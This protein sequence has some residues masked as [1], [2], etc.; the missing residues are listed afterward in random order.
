MVQPQDAGAGGLPPACG[1]PSDCPADFCTPYANKTLAALARD[2]MGPFLLAGIAVKVNPRVVP[3]WHQYLY[4]GTG[5]QD[6]SSEFGRDFTRSPTTEDTTDFLVEAIRESIERD[7]PVFPPGESEVEVDLQ[8]RIPATLSRVGTGSNPEAMNFNIPEDIP[9]NIAGGVGKTQTTCP[10]GAQPGPFDD[11]R[12]A[13][14]TVRVSRNADGSLT[15]TPQ[16]RFT[17]KDTIDLC[18]GNCGAKR[19]RIATVPLSR[20]EASGVS[21]D[22]PFTV[23]FPAPKRSFV[24]H[25]A[26]PPPTP[27]VTFPGT[28]TAS[29][30]R[31]RQEPSLSSPILGR[32]PRGTRIEVLCQTRGDEVEGNPMWN[33]TDRGYVS[34][35]YVRREDTLPPAC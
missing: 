21:G 14:G 8:T 20:L 5:V 22:V 4:G 29:F 23:Q 35:R 10:V 12:S 26:S 7:P 27:T 3:L 31:I 28:T 17:V 34:D 25:P 1:I 15:V 13:E 19:E 11:E 33:K 9:G 18:P 6:L 24:V 30:L 16:I 2:Q 32:Y